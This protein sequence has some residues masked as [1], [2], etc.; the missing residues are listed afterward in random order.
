VELP[1]ELDKGPDDTAVDLSSNSFEVRPFC[2]FLN[3]CKEQW[4]CREQWRLYC[5]KAHCGGLTWRL[6]H[7]PGAGSWL[8]VCPKCYTS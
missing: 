3:A 1:S 8:C 7:D 4:P 5:M 2:K 6:L